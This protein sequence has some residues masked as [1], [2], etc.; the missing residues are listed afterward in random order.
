MKKKS[1]RPSENYESAKNE[2]NEKPS[3]NHSSELILKLKEK[4]DNEIKCFS[5]SCDEITSKI[6][7]LIKNIDN[8]NSDVKE[9]KIIDEESDDESDE[10]N[11]KYKK[12]LNYSNDNNKQKYVSNLDEKNLFKS[13]N[14]SFNK[15]VQNLDNKKYD[16]L[17]K[18]L[19]S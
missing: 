12:K 15:I 6:N 19:N 4:I 13:L 7:D 10:E 8:N 1:N 17:G 11:E 2:P 3:E 18:K 14:E 16:Y 5:S 9:H